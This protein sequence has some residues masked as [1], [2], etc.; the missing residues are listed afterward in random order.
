L[1]IRETVSCTFISKG[2][3]LVE[4][5]TQ[6]WLIGL[7][8][9]KLLRRQEWYQYIAKTN[10]TVCAFVKASADIPS[11]EGDLKG[12]EAGYILLTSAAASEIGKDVLG[13]LNRWEGIEP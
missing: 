5:P 13:P 4:I 6:L 12:L 3:R 7:S 9:L 2:A 11:F 10:N 8:V 1:C